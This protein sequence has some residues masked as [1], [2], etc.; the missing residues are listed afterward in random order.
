MLHHSY[1]YL[2]L[3]HM[4]PLMARGVVGDCDFVSFKSLNVAYFEEISVLCVPTTLAS[5]LS[6]S[7]MTRRDPIGPR[8]TNSERG[9]EN[10]QQKGSPHFD[11]VDPVHRRGHRT[12]PVPVPNRLG[13]ILDDLG[14][15]LVRFGPGPI[16]AYRGNA[17]GKRAL[18]GERGRL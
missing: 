16:R 3:W 4:N 12:L 9:T 11:R 6:N 8:N 10:T 5:I 18:Q 15:F 1:N 17:D 2:R 13:I 14:P 7:D